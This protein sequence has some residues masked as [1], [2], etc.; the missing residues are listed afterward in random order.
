MKTI[1]KILLYTI[2]AGNLLHGADQQERKIVS[3]E[4]PEYPAIAMKMNLHGTVKLKVWI[5]AD[6]S[7][8]RLEYI[9]G[10]PLLAESALKA[11]KNWKYQSGA[12]ESTSQVEVKF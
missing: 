2:L 5:N 11:V 12:R 10:H 8:R 1:A 3:R 4:D 6:G 7:V 9:G